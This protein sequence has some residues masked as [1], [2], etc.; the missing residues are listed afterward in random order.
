MYQEWNQRQNRDATN[1][2]SEIG[3]CACAN[4]AYSRVDII[5]TGGTVRCEESDDLTTGETA[6]ISES[7]EDSLNTIGWFWNQTIGTRR[8]PFGLWT[9]N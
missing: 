7:R 4:I 8:R 9:A 2:N 3:V 1:E 6:S 5:S